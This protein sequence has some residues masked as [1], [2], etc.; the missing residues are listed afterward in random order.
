MNIGII[1]SKPS[2]SGY[3]SL[4]KKAGFNVYDNDFEKMINDCNFIFICVETPSLNNG[5]FNHSY[6]DSFIN[7]FCDL[8]PKEEKIIIIN[9][10]VIPEYCSS[11]QDSLINAQ[12]NFKLIYN[13]IIDFQQPS[14][15]LLGYDNYFDEEDETL[16]K[17]IAIYDKI[18]QNQQNDYKKMMLYEAE[19][20]KLAISSYNNSKTTYFN[21]IGDLVKAK[22]YNPSNVIDAIDG[23]GVNNDNYYSFTSDDKALYNYSKNNNMKI[24]NYKINEENNKRHLKFRFSELKNSKRPIEFDGELMIKQS[25]YQ[26][27][28]L[29][30]KL[31]Y[32]KKE[33]VIV[34]QIDTIK[35][36]EKEYNDLF[37]YRLKE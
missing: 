25:Y 31:A 15:F 22:G 7:Y 37:L 13:P 1:G 27:I 26:E 4:F 34:G 3:T 19:I 11:V 17:I 12:C 10:T 8:S 23:N 33:V 36:L 16:N 21:I 32:H 5:S 6:I 14:I 29:A 28:E 9:S 24:K 30:T 20:T 35:Q 18:Y 2:S